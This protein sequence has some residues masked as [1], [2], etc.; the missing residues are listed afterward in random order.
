[1]DGHW[2]IAAQLLMEDPPPFDAMNRPTAPSAERGEVPHTKLADERWVNVGLSRI[3]A[4]DEIFDRRQKL[5]GR[6]TA[7]AQT[8]AEK[9]KAAEEKEKKR[10]AE[11]AAKAPGG[12]EGK[13]PPKGK[14]KGKVPE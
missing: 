2:D 12:P 8:A 3:Q 1:M 11:E 13:A 9:R 7:N 5:R 10:L 14:G 4:V 6:G